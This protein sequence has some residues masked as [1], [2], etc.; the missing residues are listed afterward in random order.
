M[1]PFHSVTSAA[2]LL[3]PYLH[4]A[5]VENRDLHPLYIYMYS[6]Y[7][8]DGRPVVAIFVV[9]MDLKVWQSRFVAGFRHQIA[10]V[11]HEVVLALVKGGVVG[12]TRCYACGGT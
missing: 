4:S 12:I 11:A 10:A 8:R 9:S 6:L 7:I 1:N 3:I 5:T 2:H